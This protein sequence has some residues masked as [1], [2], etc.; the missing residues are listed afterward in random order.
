[1]KL[2]FTSDELISGVNK[3][4]LGDDGD[5][6][7]DYIEAEED[8]ERF[9]VYG[10]LITYTEE[11]EREPAFIDVLEAENLPEEPET[12]GDYLKAGWKYYD[13]IRL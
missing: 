9:Q 1:M 12:A 3:L 2:Y 10:E 13:I 8:Y 7:A 4:D 11:E 6:Q 5:F